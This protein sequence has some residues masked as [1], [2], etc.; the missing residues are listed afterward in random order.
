MI[1][2]SQQRLSTNS[3]QSVSLLHDH[4]R[5]NARELLTAGQSDQVSYE[6]DGNGAFTK[7]LVEGLSGDAFL[8]LSWIT[9]QQLLCF[10]QEQMGAANNKQAPQHF[11]FPADDT[12][13][14]FILEQPNCE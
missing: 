12:D 9:A 4:L 8:G 5:K 3:G 11:R 1:A 2:V 14:S 6:M 10:I 13:G 7:I